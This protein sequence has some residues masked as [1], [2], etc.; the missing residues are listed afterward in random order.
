MK[1]KICKIV[2]RNTAFG[3]VEAGV[4]FLGFH[5]LTSQDPEKELRAASINGELIAAGFDGG[6]L[7]TK[8]TDVAWI[9]AAA[10]AGR[11]R[12]VQLHR[13]AELDAVADLSARLGSAGIDLIQ[14][15][16]PVIRNADY[17]EQALAHAAFVLYDNYTG[18]TGK[19]IPDDLLRRF[20]SGRAF[21]AGGID[22]ARARELRDGYSPYALDVQSWVDLD[23]H[24]KDMAKVAALLR[25]TGSTR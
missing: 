9:C 8:S 11:Y 7:L 21:V 17:V 18:G 16:D 25:L 23:D 14:V 20:P 5:V 4:D 19:Q 13:G 2:D 22:D 10:A 15:V 3:L 24:T 12:F 1:L 6:V